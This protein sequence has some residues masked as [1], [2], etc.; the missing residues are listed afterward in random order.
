VFSVAFLWLGLHQDLATAI[1]L[2]IGAASAWFAAQPDALSLAIAGALFH[3]ASVYDGVDGEVAR[4]TLGESPR[5]ARL[6]AL[7]DNATY[8]GCFA[9]LLVGH[10]RT[11]VSHAL[12]AA[13]AAVAVV[14]IA[15]AVWL[16]RDAWPDARSARSFFDRFQMLPTC[17]RIASER[18]PSVFLRVAARS[19]GVL[20]TSRAWVALAVCLLS[21]LGRHWLLLVLVCAALTV[22]NLAFLVAR[23]PMLEAAATLDVASSGARVRA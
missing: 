5:G 22:A 6:D 14:A 12:G 4:A 9:A 2:A 19:V 10:E 18:Q 17:V 20:K 13:V 16:V 8:I 3:V 1:C 15:Q 7:V 11:G 23:R 21:L